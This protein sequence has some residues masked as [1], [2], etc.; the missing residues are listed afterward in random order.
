MIDFSIYEL[1]FFFLILLITIKMISVSSFI[2]KYIQI[3]SNI[4]HKIQISYRMQD[5]RSVLCV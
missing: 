3:H 5:T 4:E 2:F 1:F